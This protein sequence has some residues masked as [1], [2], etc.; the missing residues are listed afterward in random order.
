MAESS[1]KWQA[2]ARLH[3]IHNETPIPWGVLTALFG[4]Y[5]V[6]RPPKVP[7]TWA[8]DKLTITVKG[9]WDA[10]VLQAPRKLQSLQEWASSGSHRPKEFAYLAALEAE[11]PECVT[12]RPVWD[13]II[14]QDYPVIWVHAFGTL[15][16]T[17]RAFPRSAVLKII[18]G[19][20]YPLSPPGPFSSPEVGTPAERGSYWED[21]LAALLLGRE[22]LNLSPDPERWAPILSALGVLQNEKVEGGHLV[23]VAVNILEAW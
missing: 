6:P 12:W 3:R 13:G 1:W 20:K 21:S 17:I 11:L 7:Q 15:V 10:E 18:G 8:S 9:P 22:V 4:D 2:V 5:N 16:A 14:T 19:G 23:R